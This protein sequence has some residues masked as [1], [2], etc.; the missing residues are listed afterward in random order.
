MPVDDVNNSLCSVCDKVVKNSQRGIQRD[1]CNRWQHMACANLDL[2]TYRK[3][4][5]SAEG[6]YCQVCLS[7]MF[8]FNLLD[9][10]MFMKTFVCIPINNKFAGNVPAQSVNYLNMKYV[11][12]FEIFRCDNADI[13]ADVFSSCV[14]YCRVYWHFQIKCELQY[15]FL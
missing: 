6:W 14:Y 13:T 15:T 7:A 4:S 1:I 5:N 9:N 2:R 10:E 12:N 11:P 8:P 3:L